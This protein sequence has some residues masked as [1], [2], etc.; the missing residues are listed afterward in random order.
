[1]RIKFE[2]AQQLALQW[3]NYQTNPVSVGMLK[4]LQMPAVV[5]KPSKGRL[6][7]LS[8]SFQMNDIQ[9]L[10]RKKHE[11]DETEVERVRMEKNRRDTARV[12]R[13]EQEAARKAKK[14]AEM[15]SVEAAW[16]KCGGG[17]TCLRV[18]FGLELLT[19]PVQGLKKCGV[20]GE[21]KKSMCA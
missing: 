14:D 1:M 4:P 9:G 16:A 2:G 6:T 10:K 15:A 19:C 17:C 21:I 20:C 18:H 8:G 12:T 3:E 5:T 13:T 7:D 11:E